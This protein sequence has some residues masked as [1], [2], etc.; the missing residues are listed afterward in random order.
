MELTVTY[1]YVE[2]IVPPRCRK[3]RPVRFDD[4]AV[5]L[6]IRE[7]T[8]DQAPVAIIGHGTDIATG[9]NL[10]PVV[11]RWFDGRLWADGPISDCTRRGSKPHVTPGP[12]LDLVSDSSVLS[13][14]PLGIHCGVY[15]GKMAIADYLHTCCYDWL[16]IDG[17]LH[18]PASEPMFVVMTFGMTG[19]HG[20]TALMTADVLNP[21][22]R[23]EAYFSVLEL[24]KATEYTLRIAGERGDTVKV[25]TDPG[26]Q[27]EVLIPEAVQW[28]NPALKE[29]PKAQRLHLWPGKSA[30]IPA[31]SV[32]QEI[33]VWLGDSQLFDATGFVDRLQAYRELMRKA[34][35]HVWPGETV[36]AAYDYEAPELDAHTEACADRKRAITGRLLSALKSLLEHE[37]TV[38]YTGIGE[39]PSDELQQARHAAQSAIDEAEAAR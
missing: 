19:N 13:Y 21:N 10:K 28:S 6:S 39:M 36:H 14:S 2:Q 27:F 3:P 35:E 24:E 18:C 34:F 38:S 16:M 7:V 31:K 17:Q 12:I 11:Y 37:G 20:G 32:V 25:N 30:G 23:S 9:A 29:T 22:I 1:S 4:G 33:P 8:S 15:E 5:V 26:F